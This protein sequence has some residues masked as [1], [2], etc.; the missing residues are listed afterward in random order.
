MNLGPALPL[1]AD[2]KLPL[3]QKFLRSVGQARPGGVNY[4]CDAAVL[5]ESR[6]GAAIGSGYQTAAR[7]KIFTERG[8]G[9]TRR[10]ELFLRRGGAVGGRNSERSVR[11]GRHRA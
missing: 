7:A 5:H 4:F 1:E 9:K 8:P 2:T 10:R 11:A 3:V 6:P